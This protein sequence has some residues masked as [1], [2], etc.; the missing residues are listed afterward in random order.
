MKEFIKEIKDEYKK[1]MDYVD[2]TLM[3]K[4]PHA[5]KQQIIDAIIQHIANDYAISF[6]QVKRMIEQ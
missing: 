5:D 4:Y 3:E 1:N 2:N 6:Y